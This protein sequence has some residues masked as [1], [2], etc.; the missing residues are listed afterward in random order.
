MSQQKI[1]FS[2]PHITLSRAEDGLYCLVAES[3]SLNDFVEDHLWDH[4]EYQST[5]VFMEDRTKTVVYSN[6]IDADFPEERLLELMKQL[7]L[8]E[9]E[10]RFH[11]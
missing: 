8:N 7:D 4:L 5:T 2:I 6:Y 3:S 10:T 11:S 9:V 1:L